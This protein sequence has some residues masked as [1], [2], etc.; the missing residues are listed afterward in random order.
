MLEYLYGKG[1]GSKIAGADRKEGDWVGAGPSG[2][3]G[4]GG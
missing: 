3:T 1:F 4:C 2:E